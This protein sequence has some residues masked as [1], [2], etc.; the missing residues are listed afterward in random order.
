MHFIDKEFKLLFVKFLCIEKK[1]E[2][3][4]GI[5]LDLLFDISLE[6]KGFYI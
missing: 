2:I 1:E 3:E 4:N 5:G 6:R